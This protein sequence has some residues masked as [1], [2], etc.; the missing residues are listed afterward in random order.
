MDPIRN[1]YAPGAGTPPPELTGREALIERARILFARIEA[2]RS[3]KSFIAVGLRGVGKTVLLS[4]IAEMAEAKAFRVC[5]FEARE[6]KRLAELLIPQL[7]RVLL[8][9]D[10]RG[11]LSEQV[12]RGLRILKSFVGGLRLKYADIELGLD[13]EPETGAADSGDLEADLPELF[14]AIGRAARARETAV[15]LIIDEIQYLSTGDMSALIMALHRT[16]QLNLPIVLVA[17]GLPQVVGQTGKSKS[18]A[19]RLFDFPAVGA[20][21]RLDAD[22]AI[23]IPA[24]LQQVRFEPAA[25]DLI[26]GVTQGYPYFLQE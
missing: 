25:L 7:R 20:L 10:R 22:R 21:D 9:L 16:T 13:I 1:P 11:Q 24:E 12:K 4:R 2:G 26:F 5:L 6:G 19:E 17:A 23:T 18:Y 3:E 14:V 15:A 8:E